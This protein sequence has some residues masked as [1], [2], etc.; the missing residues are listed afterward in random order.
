MSSRNSCSPC[1]CATLAGSTKL[2]L[3]KYQILRPSTSASGSPPSSAFAATKGMR[4]AHAPSSSPR[5][6][7]GMARPAGLAPRRPRSLRGTGV[8]A[9]PPCFSWASW[10]RPTRTPP[11]RCRAHH[12][13][14]AGAPGLARPR[15]G[16]ASRR[17]LF[18]GC[19]RPR[20]RRASCR[21]A[22]W[23]LGDSC[24]ALLRREPLGI[25][26]PAAPAGRLRA[27]VPSRVR[28]Q[29]RRHPR[30]GCPGRHHAHAGGQAHRPPAPRARPA[31]SATPCSTAIPA[32]SQSAATSS[33]RAAWQT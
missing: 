3:R 19:R 2:R 33:C 22:R 9:K 13:P 25:A 7:S 11:H 14:R 30:G 6:R 23:R 18:R 31:A 20:R 5:R 16:R 21:R 27:R 29:H 4:S 8:G 15:A 28:P 17:P 10:S 32:S 1:S 12:W 24:R 26:P